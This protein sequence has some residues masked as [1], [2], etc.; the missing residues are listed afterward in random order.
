MPHLAEVL[1][2]LVVL[3]AVAKSQTVSLNVV[4]SECLYYAYDEFPPPS[5]WH[6]TS[7]VW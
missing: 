5:H 7:I 4:Y 3:L 1:A 6:Y 2:C